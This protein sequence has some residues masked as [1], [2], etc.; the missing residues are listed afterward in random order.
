MPL[1]RSQ[2]SRR[3]LLRV[4]PSFPLLIPE[5][6]SLD[7]ATHSASPHRKILKSLCVLVP[8]LRS[9]TTALSRSTQVPR[10]RSISSFQSLNNMDTHAMMTSSSDP[11]LSAVVSTTAADS[12]SQD[13][14]SALAQTTLLAIPSLILALIPTVTATEMETAPPRFPQLIRHALEAMMPTAPVS[15]LS[16]I[17]VMD[18]LILTV[19]A[20]PLT[21]IALAVTMITTTSA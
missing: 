14:L 1:R 7:R 2:L 15:A 8:H 4:A 16:S 20:V 5:L 21:R 17:L 3:L 18:A 11:P 10:V 9:T 19:T 13:V 6:L 12:L